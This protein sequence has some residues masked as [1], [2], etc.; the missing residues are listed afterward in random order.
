MQKKIGASS[1]LALY[2]IAYFLSLGFV[3]VGAPLGAHA[4]LSAA[5]LPGFAIREVKPISADPIA[6][7]EFKPYEKPVAAATPSHASIGRGFVAKAAPIELHATEKL[8][9]PRLKVHVRPKLS[10]EAAESYAYG[11]S[12][13]GH[14]SR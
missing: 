12:W 8:S 14:K 3:I 5:P 1:R 6:T 9:K 10:R 2:T 13:P 4:L 11:Y 7:V